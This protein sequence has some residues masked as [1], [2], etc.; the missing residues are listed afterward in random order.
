MPT[1]RRPRPL[2]APPADG[3]SAL[4]VMRSSTMAQPKPRQSISTPM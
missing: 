3:A 1:E 2:R 4:M